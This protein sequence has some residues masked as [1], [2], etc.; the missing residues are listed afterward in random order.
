MSYETVLLPKFSPNGT[1][2]DKFL[3]VPKWVRIV[4]DENNP[5]A[6][7]FICPNLSAQ[8]QKFW[9]SM[10]QRLHW[11]SVVH[12]P[13]HA[14]QQAVLLLSDVWKKWKCSYGPMWIFFCRG[15]RWG[16]EANY[17]YLIPT[18]SINS[19]SSRPR[20]SKKPTVGQKNIKYMSTPIV[21]WLVFFC[22]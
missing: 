6:Q 12:D 14:G 17:A 16:V 21:Q 15:R 19:A 10:K 18:W 2:M 8:A 4:P 3:T 22:L 9:I 1:N 20:E 7:K 11:A 5:N 13:C